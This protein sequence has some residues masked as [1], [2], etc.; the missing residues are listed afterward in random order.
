MNSNLESEN[1]TNTTNTSKH[2]MNRRDFLKV[3]SMAAATLSLPGRYAQQ[4]AKA[5]TAAPRLPVVWLEFQDCT[6]DTESF[7]RASPVQDP[8]QSGKTDPQIT[9]L[10]LDYISLDYHETI[11]VPSGVNSEKSLRD[12]VDNYSGQFVAV[13]EG[14]IPTANNGIY[15]TIGGRTALS[16]AQEVLP[17]ARAVIALGACSTDGGLAAAAPNPTQAKGVNAAVPGL[18]NLVNMPGCP[19]NVVN[20]VAVIVYLITFNQLPPLDSQ[21]RPLFAYGDT[22]HDECPRKDFYEENRFVL[23]WGDEGHKNGWCLYKMGCKGPVT[24]SNCNQVKWNQKTNWPVE[25]GHPCIGCASPSFWD[26]LPSLYTPVP[27]FDD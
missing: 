19:A 2:R 21:K 23:A 12:I 8:L 4:I 14:S 6:G 22:I 18:A 7:L 10:L 5:L 9:D 13:V 3:C 25:A 15:C 16:R 27:N 24:R 17:H 11:M 26:S 20:L 1:Q